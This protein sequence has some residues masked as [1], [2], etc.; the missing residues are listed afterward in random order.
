MNEA[1]PYRLPRTV[2]PVRYE[3]ELAPDLDTATFTGL[4]RVRVRAHEPVDEVV[5]NAADLTV[6]EAWFE[7]G[8]RRVDAAVTFDPDRQRVTLAAGGGLAAGDAVV[9][10]RFGGTLNDQLRG[11]YRSRYTADDGTEHTVACTQFEAT[12]ARR[13]FPCFDEPDRKAV[14]AVSLVVGDGLTAI[15]NEAEVASEPLG[16]G[17][18]RVR[19]ADTVPMS[20][21]L[22]AFVVGRLEATAPVDVDG[23]PLRVVHVPGKGHLSA[24][25]LEVG[26]F[27][28]RW[29]RDYYDVAYPAG[30]CDLVALPD[31]AAGAME[32]LGCITFRES[33]LLIDPAGATQAERQAV[34]DVVAH[35][36]AHM[37]FGDLVTMAWWNGLWLN[38]AFA[39]FMEVACSD[40][41]R[42]QWRRWDAFGVERSTAMATDA[43]TTTRPIEFEVRSPED[44]EG[45]FDVL[46]YEKGASVLRMLEQ[47]LGAERFRDGV[48]HYL[49]THAFANTETTDLWDRIEEVTGEPVRAIMDSWIFQGGFPIV[50]VGMSAGALTID[51]ERFLYDP[52][53]ADGTVWQVPLLL[54]DG[55][56][57]TH[58]L[59]LDG[60]TATA[61]SAPAPI[62]ANAGGHGFLRVHYDEALRARLLAPATLASLGAVERFGL[63]DDAWASVVSGRMPAA[64]FVALAATFGA[65]GD[66]TVWRTLYAGLL[67]CDRL[68]DGEARAGLAGRVRAVAGEALERLGWERRDGEDDLTREL[69]GLLVRAAAITG[70]DDAVASRARAAWVASLDDPAAIDPPLAAAGLT[71][72]AATGGQAEHHLIADRMRAAT[73][74]QEQLRYLYALAELPSAELMDLTCAMAMSADVRSQNAPYLLRGCLRNRDHGERAWRFVRTHWGEANER[75]PRS[76][77]VRMLEGVTTLSRP[78][79][80]AEVAGFFA[81][82]QV[83]QGARTLAQILERLRVNVALREREAPALARALVP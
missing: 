13:A 79:L 66:L 42:P 22:V 9:C 3:L 30:K 35:E 10:A 45:M 50:S 36:L 41:F 39:T 6:E 1:D 5:L 57:A 24:F 67:E 54:R 40:A 63:V 21:Y 58:R 73:T 52:E 48:R 76:S 70:R 69:R 8:G 47:Y 7:Q 83:P 44:A 23:V 78:A 34:A 56:G 19:F 59:L 20:T 53:A 2:E 68:V 61:G 51:Q 25:A 81:E 60:T 62:V 15:S 71:V 14:F 38:E 43:L 26:A 65:E 29:F 16:D 17:R 77:I 28:L 46:T 75:F 72:T 31:F 80:A 49:R 74:P 27:A 32:N 55:S 64:D 11:F 18:R 37:W 33:L 4:A 12:D 82:H